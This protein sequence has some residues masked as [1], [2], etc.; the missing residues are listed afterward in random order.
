MATAA[1][2]LGLF[3]C[4][5]CAWGSDVLEHELG[6]WRDHPREGHRV[7]VAAPAR[8]TLLAAV[9]GVGRV[10]AVRVLGLPEAVALLELGWH[11]HQLARNVV[12]GST[13]TWKGWNCKSAGWRLHN[14]QRKQEVPTGVRWQRRRRLPTTG[15]AAE[16][17]D[18]HTLRAGG[19]CWGGSDK[20]SRQGCSNSRGARGKG[21]SQAW[22]VS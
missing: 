10:A 8:P 16:R 14:S 1:S 22:R 2:A 5:A 18:E 17:H 3:S 11:Q 15:R 6:G 13:R 7:R 12:C 21:A 20:A 4:T 9:P 19:C